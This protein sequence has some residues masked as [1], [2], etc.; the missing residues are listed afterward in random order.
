MGIETKVTWNGGV[1]NALA[2]E[3]AARGLNRAGEEL[4]S[5][6]KERSPVDTGDNR[7][8]AG[9]HPALPHDLVCWVVYNMP[10]STTIHE[11][12]HM[13]FSAVKNPNAQAKFLE[14]PL[15]EG[16]EDYVGVI[17]AELRR[18]L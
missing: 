9:L 4:L 16:R 1:L 14:G 5:R 3:A 2:R 13:H 7:R 17:G 11:G 6:S 15:I 10:Y 8:S 12:V 18:S